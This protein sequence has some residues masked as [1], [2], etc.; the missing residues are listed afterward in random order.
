MD[1]DILT[2]WLVNLPLEMSAVLTFAIGMITRNVLFLI[3]AG[4]FALSLLQ[5][6]NAYYKSVSTSGVGLP[7]VTGRIP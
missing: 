6:Y 4:F 7:V 5:V 1:D 3:L 2:V